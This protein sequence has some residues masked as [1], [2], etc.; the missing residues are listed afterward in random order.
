MVRYVLHA[1]GISKSC[2]W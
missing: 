1:N 2:R